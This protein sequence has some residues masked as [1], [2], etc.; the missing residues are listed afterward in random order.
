M[1]WLLHTSLRNERSCTTFIQ[2]SSRY[3]RRSSPRVNLDSEDFFSLLSSSE[4][5]SIE[6]RSTSILWASIAI[7]TTCRYRP[8]LKHRSNNWS[9]IAGNLVSTTPLKGFD[10]GRIDGA[11]S[12]LLSSRLSNDLEGNVDW[13]KGVVGEVRLAEMLEAPFTVDGKAVVSFDGGR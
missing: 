10:D 6:R 7:P 2:I 9:I 5:R 1:V 4:A 13:V 3:S 8:S 12:S 11:S